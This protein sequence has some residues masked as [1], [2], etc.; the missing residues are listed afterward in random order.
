MLK[1]ITDCFLLAKKTQTSST[2]PTLFMADISVNGKSLYVLVHLFLIWHLM[3]HTAKNKI[4]IEE[5]SSF[6]S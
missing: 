2:K 6:P 1:F 3:V 4:K 5:T